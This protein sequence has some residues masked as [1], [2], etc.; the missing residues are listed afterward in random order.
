MTKAIRFEKAG[1]PEVLKFEDVD[2]P[3]P[4]AGQARV[5]HTAIGVNFIDIYHRSG[6]YPLPLPSGLGLE[7]AGIV[8]ALGPGVT[9]W[10]IGDRVAY[11]TGPLGAYSE[12]ANVPADRVVAIP[13]SVDDETAAALMLK[14]LTAW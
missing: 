4:P 9:Q 7:A 13:D 12:V 2:L 1:G 8:E 6:L 10:N 5:R 14:G 11:G 3:P